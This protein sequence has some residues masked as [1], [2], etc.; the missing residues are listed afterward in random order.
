MLNA[1]IGADNNDFGPHNFWSATG[2]QFWLVA[3]LA[4]VVA[5]ASGVLFL[6]AVSPHDDVSM[7]FGVSVLVGVLVMAPLT[8][9][10]VL[11]VN[12]DVS[13]AQD[14]NLA[15]LSAAYPN[16]EV[17]S[18]DARCAAKVAAGV[19]SCKAE[20]VVAGKIVKLKFE[21]VQDRIVIT[22]GKRV[23]TSDSDLLPAPVAAS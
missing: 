14:T 16:L 10:T 4:V 15:A 22:A 9:W 6:S 13:D 8:V 21:S 17:G 3:A 19:D 11:G 20:R 2:W 18:A 23:I 7:R 12:G 1:I 5:I